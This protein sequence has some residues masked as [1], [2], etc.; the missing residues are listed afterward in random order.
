MTICAGIGQEPEVTFTARLEPV[1]ERKEEAG[2]GARQ[3]QEN[4]KWELVD[5]HK[6]QKLMRK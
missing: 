2:P 6:D 3:K 4:G 1:A 5:N